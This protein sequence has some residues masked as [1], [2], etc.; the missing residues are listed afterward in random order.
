MSRTIRIKAAGATLEIY[1]DRLGIPHVFAQN[2]EDAFIGMGYTAGYEMLWQIH[3]SCLYANGCAASVLG[4]RFLAQDVLH[5]TF[6][7]PVERIGVPESEGDWIA[8]EYLEGLNAYVDELSEVPPEFQHA[9]TEPR[10]FTLPTSLPG[11]GFPVGFN[12]AHGWRKS[13]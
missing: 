2:K 10:R 4:R 12:I 13:T 5:R 1:W 8:D 11:T 7:V 9:D 6:D 3:L